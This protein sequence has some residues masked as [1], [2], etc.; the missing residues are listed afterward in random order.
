MG[1]VKHFNKYNMWYSFGLLLIV[2]I[3]VAL[4]FL[5]IE[6]LDTFVSEQL[7]TP[8][9]QHAKTVQ[10]LEKKKEAESMMEDNSMME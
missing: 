9:V 2:T 10:D 1:F 7:N 3:L 5:R 8:T 4:L 6:Q